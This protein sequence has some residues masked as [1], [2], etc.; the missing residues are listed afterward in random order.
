[1]KRRLL[2][3]TLALVLAGIGTSGVL[4]YA[5]GADARAIT[6]MKAV[7]VLVAKEAIPSGTSA[8]AALRTGLL[9][10]EKLPAA[11][12]PSDAVRSVTSAL[13]P[14]FTSA[15]VQPGE[16]LLRAMLVKKAVHVSVPGSVTL[17]PGMIAV[18]VNFCLTEA[19][20]GD[21][22]AGSRVAVFDT[23]VPGTG[24]AAAGCSGQHVEQPGSVQT[25]VVLARVQVMS[26]GTPPAGGQASSTSSGAP[27]SSAGS[28]TLVTLAVSQADAE[29]L[30]QVTVTGLPY[31]ALLSSASRTS[32]DAGRLLDSH[33]IPS[34]TP[35]PT[36]PSPSPTPTATSPS[37]T[38]A[39]GR[40][41]S[42]PT[43]TPTK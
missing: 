26:V 32:A 20:A 13:A 29:R 25:R 21:L 35:T 22:Q 40:P 39:A 31:L 17:P 3:I 15:A 42:T 5:K 24:S 10:T 11:S 14:L 1:M 2:I 4:A 12:V 30:I 23:I 27:S 43:P 9:G 28:S 36:K 7:S 16:L 19:V 34:P 37:P 41:G 33:S 38:P 6:G 18:S 8:G